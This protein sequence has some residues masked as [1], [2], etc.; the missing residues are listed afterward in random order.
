MIHEQIRLCLSSIFMGR[1]GIFAPEPEDN[2]VCANLIR[3]GT[4]WRHA[5]ESCVCIPC[6]ITSMHVLP[7]PRA[8]SEVEAK[9]Y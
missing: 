6:T 3:E 5:N 8:V 2:W 9:K 4:V 1:N 7:F